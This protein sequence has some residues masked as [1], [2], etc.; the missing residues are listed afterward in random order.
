MGAARTEEEPEAE[1]QRQNEESTQTETESKE[2][3]ELGEST[4]RGT[5]RQPDQLGLGQIEGNF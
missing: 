5:D 1:Q 3:E 4:R 2:T